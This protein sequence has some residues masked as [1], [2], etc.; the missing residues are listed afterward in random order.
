VKSADESTA[1]VLRW[2]FYAAAL[3]A[4]ADRRPRWSVEGRRHFA[5]VVGP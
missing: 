2:V 5:D 3:L 1:R 4:Q